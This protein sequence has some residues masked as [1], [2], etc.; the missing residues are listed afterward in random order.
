VKFQIPLH[1]VDCIGHPLSFALGCHP[2]FQV[3][4]PV[5]G[6]LPVDVM[7]VLSFDEFSSES[8]L[9][10]MAVFFNRLTVHANNSIAAVVNV[11]T[12]I[13]RGV[14]A[15][16]VAV[17]AL[18]KAGDLSPP[19]NAPSLIDLATLRARKSW[20]RYS[21]A[22]M[23][24]TVL[25]LIGRGTLA[26]AKFRDVRIFSSIESFSTF[27]ANI[28]M[29][30]RPGSLKFW[31]PLRERAACSASHRTEFLILSDRSN[32]E[33]LIAFLADFLN[34]NGHVNSSPVVWRGIVAGAT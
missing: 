31:S 26:A 17:H 20:C 27:L 6:T 5:V 30:F 34:L 29:S 10:H 15:F 32:G 16:S 25:V 33:R 28:W 23:S 21:W 9:H 3:F 11:T 24:S 7:D 12:L 13:K 2:Q 8:L 1:P 19:N 4:I 14:L 18:V 22:R